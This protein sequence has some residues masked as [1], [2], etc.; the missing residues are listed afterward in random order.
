MQISRYHP[1]MLCQASRA[2]Y[3]RDADGRY[4]YS[5]W[6][7]TN[8]VQ[9]MSAHTRD[10][11]EMSTCLGLGQKARSWYGHRLKNDKEDACKDAELGI[12]VELHK[13]FTAMHKWMTKATPTEG[14]KLMQHGQHMDHLVEEVNRLIITKIWVSNRQRRCDLLLRPNTPEISHCSRYK[15]L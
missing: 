11:K 13:Q 5:L 2:A 7:A 6:S 12:L 10:I 8:T 1:G 15:I 14:A 3:C 4:I 9:M